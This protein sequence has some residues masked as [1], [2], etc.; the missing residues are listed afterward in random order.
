MSRISFDNINSW[1]DFKSY[2]ESL[3]NK[4]QMGDAF[5]HLTYLYFKLDPKYSFYDEVY[6]MSEVPSSDLEKLKIPRQDLGIDLIAKAGK[7]YHPIQ[8]KYHTDKKRSIKFPEVST[9]LTQ[10]NSNIN[11]KMGYIASSADNTS[12][13]Y[14]KVNTKEVQ[15]LLYNTWYK[16]D[17][18]FFNRVREFEKGKEYSP[19]P[20]F[21]REHQ[22]KAVENAYKHFIKENNSRGKLIFPCGA[23]KSLTGYWM[24]ERLASKSTIVAVPSLSLIKQT[25]DVYL[26]EVAARNKSVK[27]LCICSDEG[28]GK[29]DDVLYKTNEVGVPCTTDED[30]IKSWLKRNKKEEIIVFTTYQSGR[31][32]ADISKSLN[33]IFDLGIYDEAH[34]TVGKNEGL[35][36]Y[37]LFE[38]NISIK[39]RIFMTATERFYRGVKDDVLT[40]DDPEDYGEVFSHM[41]FKEAIE[42]ELLTDYKVITIEVKKEEVAE[43]IKE[44]NLVKLNAKWGKESEA[45]SLASMIAL[46]KAM[47]TLPI[48]NAVSFHSSIDRAV[49]SKEVQNYI[50]ETYNYKPIETFTVSGKL[51][52]SKREVI[53]NEFANSNKAL[54][55]N[56][57]CLT[58]GVDVPNID[59]I[60]FADPRKSK[61]DIVQALGRALRKKKGKEWGYVILPIIYDH[62]SQEI[63]NDNFQEILNIVRGLAAN[64][65]RIIEEF[66][67]KSN[68]KGRVIGAREEIFS[69]DPV[70]LE[71]SEL[72]NNVSIRL[73]E[74]L[75]RFNWMPFTEARDFVRS[76][77]IKSQKEWREYCLSGER[78]SNI[79]SNP[80]KNYKNQWLSISD[81]IGTNPG[82]QGFNYLPY[83]EAK[84]YVN[85]LG[86]KSQ[87]QWTIFLKKNLKPDNIPSSPRRYYLSKGWVSWGDWLGSGK[88]ADLYK[89]FRPFK[90]A[91]EYIHFLGIKTQKEWN[92][93]AKSEGDKPNDIPYKPQRTYKSEW[94]SWGDWLGTGNISSAKINYL[95]YEAAREF[96]TS[97]KL[98]SYNEWRTFVKLND[99]PENIPKDPSSHYKNKMGFF[100]IKDFLGYSEIKTNKSRDYLSYQKA[101]EKLKPLKLNSGK[102]Y[103]DKLKNKLLDKNEFPYHPDRIYKN[104]GWTSMDD[105]LSKIRYK[106]FE[107]VKAY[108]KRLKIQSGDKW[109]EHFF[110]HKVP[111]DIPKTVQKVF[112]KEWKGWTD[113]LGKDKT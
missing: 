14:N 45:R 22:E 49:R 27:W 60:V 51:P 59:C 5:E 15:K 104:N 17:E 61:V 107:S 76:L 65:E 55:T 105:F 112:K 33:I 25:L 100:D 48:K 36:S 57:R 106:D 21:P 39:N 99:I 62:S 85:S 8:C 54:I 98:N 70:L 95:S 79:P 83:N 80:E 9:F 23:G 37:L 28:I 72:A 13:I 93:Y 64:D 77:N 58:E 96:A 81:W 43:F 69:I 7:E 47:K 29:N 16:L 41:S 32:I 74:N 108:A 56:S 73:W 3:P 103:R 30:Y 20:F 86:L 113:F 92:S 6:K 71:E 52:T 42:R 44:N 94:I 46:R 87:S 88:Q 66:K 101:K 35:F 24:M 34:K 90:E 78:P 40:M 109:R 89:K 102:E 82:F 10:L 53:V 1:Q 12:K 97:L 38:K 4:K 91:R 11:F 31:I 84:K 19:E 75:S 50:S 18:S 67:D 68:N 63:D 2:A 26:K 110:T 111:A